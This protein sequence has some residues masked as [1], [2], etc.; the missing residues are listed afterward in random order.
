MNKHNMTFALEELDMIFRELYQVE[1]D[2]VRPDIESDLVTRVEN[3]KQ[4]E[5]H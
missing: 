1:I 5:N 3:W 2:R 4:K